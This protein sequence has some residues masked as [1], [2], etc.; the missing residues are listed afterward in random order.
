MPAKLVRLICWDAD[1]VP[2]RVRTLEK[3]RFRVN[4]K[5]HSPGRIV[6]ETRDIGPDAIVIDLDRLPSHGRQIALVL[7]LSKSTRAIPI[8]F[9]GGEPGKVARVK[10]ELPD[11]VYAAWSGIGPAIRE[12]LA[13]APAAPVKPQGVMERYAGTPL[14]QKLG[15][16]PGMRVAAIGAPESF[17]ELLGDLPEGATIEPRVRRDTGLAIW[18]AHSLD[19][20]ASAI[21]AIAPFVNAARPVWLASPKKSGAHRVDF[22]INDVRALCNEADLVDYKICAIDKD[23]TAMKIARRR[24]SA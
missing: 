13:N 4:A 1:M 24:K 15:I 18:F 17:E 14:A 3:A 11:A 5:P 2:E 23:W 7:R 12:A 19:E 9:A 6:G 8:V 10:S 16:K 22:T 21:E 20:L